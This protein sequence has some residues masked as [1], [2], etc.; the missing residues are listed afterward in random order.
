MA[1][2]LR[3]ISLFSVFHTSF[4]AVSRIKAYTNVVTWVLTS[5]FVAGED[6]GLFVVV[7]DNVIVVH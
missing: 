5:Y 1:V 6:R 4:F 7:R 2:C 3:Q